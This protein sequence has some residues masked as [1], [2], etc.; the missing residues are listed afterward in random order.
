MCTPIYASCYVISIEG[1]LQLAFLARTFTR[2]LGAI[3]IALSR[4]AAV[5]AGTPSALDIVL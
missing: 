3:H 1:R 5:H 4:C 2:E